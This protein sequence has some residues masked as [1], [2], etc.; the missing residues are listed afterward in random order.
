MILDDVVSP[1]DKIKNVVLD[2]P[3]VDDES[4]TGVSVPEAS[5]ST[6][7]DVCNRVKKNLT[8]FEKDI[9]L[10]RVSCQR[11]NAPPIFVLLRIESFKMF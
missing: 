8:G 6:P 7:E 2:L 9:F 1:C 5:V 3:N 11:D 4:N 10:P